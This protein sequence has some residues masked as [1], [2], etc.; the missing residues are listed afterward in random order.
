VAPNRLS[1]PAFRLGT[2]L[3]RETLF[4]KRILAP[5]WLAAPCFRIRDSAEMRIP[6]VSFGTRVGAGSPGAPEP[7][8][9]GVRGEGGTRGQQSNRATEQ[10]SSRGLQPLLTKVDTV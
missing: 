2:H 9:T 8:S 7:R 6:K 1:F 3:P 4:R 5:G 10:Q